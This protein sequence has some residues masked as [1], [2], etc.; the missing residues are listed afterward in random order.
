MSGRLYAEVLHLSGGG[1]LFEVQRRDWKSIEFPSFRKMRRR[2][3]QG[4]RHGLWIND[5]EPLRLYT[6]TY[7]VWIYIRLVI[8][9]ICTRVRG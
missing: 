3:G 4:G 9:F 2:E 8:N 6:V 1:V 5:N 7:F